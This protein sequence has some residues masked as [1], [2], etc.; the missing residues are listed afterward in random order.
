M[1][2]GGA[3]SAIEFDAIVAA[4]EAGSVCVCAAGN[5][6][7]G[8]VMF[9]AAHPQVIAISALGLYGTESPGSTEA[10]NVPNQPDRF[11]MGGLYL[12]SFSAVGP[13]IDATAPGNGIISTVPAREKG[14][15]PYLGLD[16]TSMACPAATGALAA[17][18]SADTHY[19][20]LPRGLARSQYV[21][22]LART[23]CLTLGLNPQY[24]G[25]GLVR[26][27]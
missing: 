27:S 13:Q 1:S 4:L 7:G 3:Y 12:A 15:A 9:P 14:S 2:L 24:Q 18:L 26:L 10:A 20:E 17:I 21:L 25:A 23:R 6:R 8:A 5:T 16:G 19:K 11:A 22:A